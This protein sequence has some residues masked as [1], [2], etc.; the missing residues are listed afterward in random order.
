[1]SKEKTSSAG[2][3]IATVLFLIFLVLKLAEIGQVKD[4]SWWW[5]TSPLWISALLVLGILVITGIFWLIVVLP[6]ERKR[7]ASG[8]SEYEW[9]M[10]KKR[11][12]DHAPKKSNFQQRLE[13]MQKE[14]ESKK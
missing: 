3:G 5:V 8:M 9:M 1:M 6:D 12:K 14:R 7:K 10:Q 11:G 13:E 2:F 4:W